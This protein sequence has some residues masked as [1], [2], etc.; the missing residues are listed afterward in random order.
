MQASADVMG[1]LLTGERMTY[2]EALRKRARQR[3]RLVPVED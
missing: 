1:G 3:L 2:E